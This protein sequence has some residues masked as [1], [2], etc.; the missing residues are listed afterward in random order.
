M[1]RMKWINQPILPEECLEP[2]LLLTASELDT[3]QPALKYSLSVYRSMC[4]G[5]EE[6]RK[7]GVL[8]D[9][10]THKLEYLSRIV[11]KLECLTKMNAV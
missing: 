3:I 6:G 8:T 7:K 11:G 1:K 4:A 10:Q 9:A 2:M 5:L